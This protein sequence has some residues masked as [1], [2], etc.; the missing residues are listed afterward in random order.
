MYRQHLKPYTG[1]GLASTQG[2]IKPYIPSE[3]LR[4]AVEL[5]YYL[6][7]P[8]LL[9]GEP[10]CGKTRLS[11]SVAYEWYGEEHKKYYHTWQIKSTSKAKEGLYNFDNLRKLY[12]V[13]NKEMKAEI[14]YITLGVLGRAFEHDEVD[15]PFVVLIDEIDKAPI[16]FPNDLLYE[17]EEMRFQIPELPTD[18]PQYSVSAK[19]AP[20]IVI[21]SNNEKDLP[22]PFLRR[23]ICHHID[24]PSQEKLR[25]ILEANGYGHNQALIE[26]GLRVFAGIRENQHME[27]KRSSTSELLDW[28]AFLAYAMQEREEDVLKTLRAF[29]PKNKTGKIP[30]FQALLKTPQDIQIFHNNIDA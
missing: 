12:D 10:G 23:C 24:F 17:L 18:H 15:K 8:L 5:A 25:E 6:N 1:K 2:K 20:F 26:E 16:D 3:S 7:R 21:T 4:T 13:Q 11:E 22:A 29:H 19:V 9:T 14:D 27:N 30:Y 28:F